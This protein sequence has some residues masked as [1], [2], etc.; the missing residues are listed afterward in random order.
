MNSYKEGSLMSKSDLLKGKSVHI[1]QNSNQ[2]FL[3][4]STHN[5]YRHSV[6]R[7]SSISAFQL[8]AAPM[9]MTYHDCERCDKKQKKQHKTHD[10]LKIE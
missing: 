7:E 4:I 3:D 6:A 10:Q 2:T 1:Y 9:L 8:I 5:L